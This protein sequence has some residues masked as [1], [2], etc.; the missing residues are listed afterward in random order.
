VALKNTN[1]FLRKNHEEMDKKYQKICEEYAEKYDNLGKDHEEIKQRYCSQISKTIILEKRIQ[2][3]SETRDIMKE[4]DEKYK[5]LR[6]NLEVSQKHIDQYKLVNEK[7]MKQNS[8][9]RNQTR[10]ATERSGKLKTENK[11]LK[12]Q[13]QKLNKSVGTLKNLSRE[14]QNKLKAQNEK[15]IIENKVETTEIKNKT[16]STKTENKV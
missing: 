9:L 5:L 14:L 2:Q 12:K 1:D 4:F 3:E 11:N 10:Q 16:E 6:E 13:N 7:L 8:S 15:K